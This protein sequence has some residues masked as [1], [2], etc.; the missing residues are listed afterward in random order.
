MAT[1]IKHSGDNLESDGWVIG[2]STSGNR[3]GARDGAGG[4]GFNV[5]ADTTQTDTTAIQIIYVAGRGAGTYYFRRYFAVFDTSQITS[6]HDVT[7][8]KISLFK[9][10]TQAYATNGN[11]ILVKSTAFGGDGNTALHHSDKRAYPGYSAATTMLNNVTTYSNSTNFN[12]SNGYVDFTLNND[13]LTDIKNNSVLIIMAVNYDHDY[14]YT[15]P[16]TS[17]HI[18]DNIRFDDYSGTSSDPK[19][20]IEYA[21]PLPTYNNRANFIKTTSGNINITSG[22]VTL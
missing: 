2:T 4:T 10:P 7:S 12:V 13:A 18:T 17:T 8:A 22:K 21:I 9:S 1:L 15:N 19:L 20:T 6:I 14:L 3:D 16:S 11:I 5:L